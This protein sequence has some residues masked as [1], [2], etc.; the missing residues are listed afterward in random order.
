MVAKR[1]NDDFGDD[2]PYIDD[3]LLK[4]HP[5]RA[6]IE[7]F[8]EAL[9]R[10]MDT[11]PTT[12]APKPKPEQRKPAPPAPRENTERPAEGYV[13]GPASPGVKEQYTAWI[14]AYEAWQKAG[15]TSVLLPEYPQLV[16]DYLTRQ[17]KV[18]P[19]FEELRKHAQG[20]IHARNEQLA[21]QASQQDEQEEENHQQQA[22][23]GA[24]PT[25]KV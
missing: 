12:R 1:C 3:A 6:N 19:E 20:F 13:K 8:Q 2:S 18:N 24:E 17:A 23:G 9:D 14:E 15:D 10:A 4:A 16:F 21:K 5:E 25:T 22:Q 7:F 11:R